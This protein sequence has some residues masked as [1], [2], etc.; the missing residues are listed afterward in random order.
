M[1]LLEAAKARHSVRQYLPKDIEGD[2]LDALKAEIEAC[3][4][5]GGLHFQYV[6][7]EPKA[8]DCMLARYGSFR[9][10]VNYVALVAAEGL[11]ERIGYYGQR[12]AVKSQQLGLNTC[13]V[14]GSYKKVPSAFE[15]AKGEKLYML[16]VV[17]YGATQG[18][19]SRSRR[20]EEVSNLQDGD[21]EWFRLGV[22][23]ALLAPT[24]LNQQKFFLK[25]DGNAVYAKAGV[26][27]YSKTDLGIVKYNFELAAGKENF[28]WR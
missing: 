13:W 5:E 27:P 14:A 7:N 18:K 11:Q 4:A 21:P 9:G 3:N 1:E 8:L 20:A 19:Q 25:R 6:A 28:E 23:Y 10:A 2:V 16:I 22:E 17:G 12:I 15:R 26:G 24:A